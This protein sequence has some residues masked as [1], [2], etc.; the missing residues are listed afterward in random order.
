MD[1]ETRRANR[2]QEKRRKEVRRQQRFVEI[3]GGTYFTQHEGML[4]ELSEEAIKRSRSL[5]KIICVPHEQRQLTDRELLNQYG[6]AG[7][8]ICTY[9]HLKG[10]EP[11]QPGFYG[12]SVTLVEDEP[13]QRRFILFLRQL[14]NTFSE[15]MMEAGHVGALLH[16]L[17]HIDDYEKGRNLVFDGRT[18]NLVAAELYAHDYACRRM[19]ARRLRVPLVCYLSVF[20]DQS[21]VK[22]ET[23][24]EAACRFRET[25]TYKRAVN[26]AGVLYQRS[27]PPTAE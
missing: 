19:I 10:A 23:A 3:R 11:E 2:K 8:S 17:G 4:A 21:F 24:A 14:P 1:R 27:T 12:G 5:L 18:V 9:E 25:A 16:E 20:I 7:W 6:L 22:G 26:F 13:R 15:S